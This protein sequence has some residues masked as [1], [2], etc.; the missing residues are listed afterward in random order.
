[1]RRLC[2]AHTVTDTHNASVGV[3]ARTHMHINITGSACGRSA[4]RHVTLQH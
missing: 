2:N 4:S 1:M 3:D